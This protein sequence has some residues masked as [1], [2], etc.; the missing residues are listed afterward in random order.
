MLELRYARQS[1]DVFLLTGGLS[2]AGTGIG[3]AV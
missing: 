3:M 1:P 2:T